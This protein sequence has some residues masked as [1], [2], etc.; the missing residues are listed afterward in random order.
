MT[1]PCTQESKIDAIHEAIVGTLTVPGI[2]TMLSDMQRD[3]EYVK[4]TVYG[5]GKP[6]LLETVNGLRIQHE[7]EEKGWGKRIAILTLLITNFV[8]LA[9]PYLGRH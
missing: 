7:N 3:M 4:K 8:A 1:M 5:N 2:R 9:V 6:G